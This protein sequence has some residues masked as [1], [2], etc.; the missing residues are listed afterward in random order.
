MKKKLLYKLSL[1]ST[2]LLFANLTHAA[3][4]SIQVQ[5]WQKDGYIVISDPVKLETLDPIKSINAHSKFT[6]PLIFES[7]VTIN[8]QQELQPALAQSWQ[9]AN[10]NKSII[11]QIKPNHRFSDNTEVTAQDV[12]NSIYR[13]CS[14]ASQEH[15]QVRGLVGC[16]EHSKGKSIKPQ[17]IA[18][19]KYTIQFNINS[20]P[21]TFLYQLSSPSTVI[22]KKT[23]NNLIGSSVYLINEKKDDFLVLA[24]NPFYN[25]NV[26][27][28]N[29]GIVM[30]Y[31]NGHDVIDMIENNKPD[32]ALMYEM[33]ALNNFNNSHYRIIKTNPN[34]TNVLVLNNQKF[35]FNKSEIRKALAADI[36]N[37][38]IYSCIPGAHKAYGI[39]PNGIGGSLTNMM[40]D[41]FPEFTPA[42]IF[43]KH[44]QLKNK[45]VSITIHQLNDIK[46][47]C[48][49]QQVI[50]SEKKYNIDIN[51][52]YHKDYSDLLPL[53]INHH[54]DGF[55]D[56]YI[57]KN[58]EAYN[59]FEFFAKNSE[60]DANIK[61]D[62]ID[63]LL[64]EAVSTPSSHGRFQ[65][66]RK[67][68]QY[69]QDEN[70]VIPLFYMDHGNLMDKCLSGISDNFIFNPFAELP[71][72][73]KIQNCKHT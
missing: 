18:T 29:T 28:M 37:N 2:F 57:F 40:P 73:S 60:N 6:L 49:S 58:R 35:P 13:L 70:I 64:K 44:P 12:V 68:A 63:S 23:S 46:T 3:I 47:S 36:Y 8:A 27:L 43:R 20:S 39:I 45:K 15:G 42:E 53:Y 14:K 10:D 30:F 38:F 65:I 5:S 1:T 32:G 25:G 34:I 66:Y 48:E 71:K 22:T 7:L 54:I 50:Q 67:I 51:F 72:I 61:S 24:K 31:V 33:I 16:E 56:L 55:I 69:M 19:D 26:K 11:I 21:T 41:S 59:I 62:A 4:T 17:V 9:I 52:K